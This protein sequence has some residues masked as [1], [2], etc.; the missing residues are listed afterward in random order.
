MTDKQKTSYTKIA[1]ALSGLAV[2][3]Q[4]AEVIWRTMD[5]LEQK[6]NRFSVNDVMHI[7]SIVKFDGAKER[8]KRATKKK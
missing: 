1:L 4:K 5:R 6:K 8:V 7:D 3:E 2:N